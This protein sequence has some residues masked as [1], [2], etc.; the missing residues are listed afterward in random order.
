MTAR[1]LR[2]LAL[3]PLAMLAL[4]GSGCQPLIQTP[5]QFLELEQTDREYDYR[6]TSADG[7]VLA[8]RVLE[9]EE[10]RGGGLDFWVDA[11]K[12]QLAR[13]GEYASLGER[14]VQTQDGVAGIQL[15]FGRD[16]HKRPYQYWITLL[17]A[18]DELVVIE[19]GGPEA[20]LTKYE[21]R[22]AA[23]IES[24]SL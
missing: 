1:S 5:P 11:V 8:V 22:I 7:V 4:G 18:A 19:A 24:L 16:E 23:A 3:A 21:P 6:A 20:K 2:R 14:K 9:F 12:L 10:K 17:I 15:R 13:T